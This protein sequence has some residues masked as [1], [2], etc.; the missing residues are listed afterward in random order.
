M[1]SWTSF[2]YITFVDSMSI[3]ESIVFD[4]HCAATL[5][6]EHGIAGRAGWILQ[7]E[8]MPLNS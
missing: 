8:V 7:D 5:H 2:V 1:L 6:L 3:V 4:L